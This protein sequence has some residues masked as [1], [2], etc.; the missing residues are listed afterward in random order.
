MPLSNSYT[1]SIV[2]DIVRSSINEVSIDQIDPSLIK[3][4]VNLSILELA[5][6]LNDSSEPDYGQVWQATVTDGLISIA[7][8]RVDRIIKLVGRTS[9]SRKYSGL[10]PPINA[11]EFENLSNLPNKQENIFHNIFGD[12]IRIYVGKKSKPY[13]LIDVYYYRQPELCDDPDDHLDVKDK[14][15]PMIIKK[16]KA[17]VLEKRGITAGASK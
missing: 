15:I 1:L 12:K 3:D 8:L 4:Y 6:E 11:M 14:H 17:Y 2:E 9:D 16:V 10:I 5:T 7:E 13:D